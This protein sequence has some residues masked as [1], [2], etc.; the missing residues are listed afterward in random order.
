MHDTGQSGFVPGSGERDS[1]RVDP[2]SLPHENH[3]SLPSGSSTPAK[4]AAGK[5]AR[6]PNASGSRRIRTGAKTRARLQ[7][8]ETR[9]ISRFG[10][11][12]DAVH[13]IGWEAEPDIS[14]IVRHRR[15]GEMRSRPQGSGVAETDLTRLHEICRQTAPLVT[16]AKTAHSITMTLADPMAPDNDFVSALQKIFVETAFPPEALRL[17]LHEQR[18]AAEN[19]DQALALAILIDWGVEIWVTRFG[20]DPSSLSLL[21]ERAASGL[22]SGISMDAALV[23]TPTGLW[24]PLDPNPPPDRLDPVATRF[25]A[26]SCEAMHALGIKTHLGRI[27]SSA[28]FAFALSAG[29]DEMGGHCRELD[30]I[31]SREALPCP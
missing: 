1:D 22:V 4:G 7:V 19:R 23:M 24:R 20:Q 5:G 18:L 16:S 14:A 28:Q 13:Q 25:F 27:T 17:T 3:A 8:P 6:G 15:Q 10:L 2:V 12:N 11:R 21:R 26:A 29:F 31:A 30:R 9:W